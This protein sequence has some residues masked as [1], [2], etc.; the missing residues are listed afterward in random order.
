MGKQLF[1][2][3]LC[4]ASPHQLVCF[5][6]LF[7]LWLSLRAR[8]VSRSH[9]SLIVRGKD[10]C[11]AHKEAS[12]KKSTSPSTEG[13]L[14]PESFVPRPCQ[15]ACARRTT[16]EVALHSKATPGSRARPPPGKNLSMLS[17]CYFLPRVRSVAMKSMLSVYKVLINSCGVIADMAWR[18][19]RCHA[20]RF[21]DSYLQDNPVP[22]TTIVQLSHEEEEP[23]WG[24]FSSWSTNSV[25]EIDLVDT[26]G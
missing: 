2:P 8:A 15:R 9:P 20:L 23:R 7:S 10:L 13:R 25:T 16:P 12:V 3:T 14:A 21:D 26:I 18:R 11:R 5:I 17:P 6:P 1:Q 4:Q 22:A 24:R 19:R